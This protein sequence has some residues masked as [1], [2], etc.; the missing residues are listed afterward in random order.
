MIIISDN[1]Y[2]DV[3]CKDSVLI[4]KI[5][6]NAIRFKFSDISYITNEND[7]RTDLKAI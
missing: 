1:V 3:Y 4:E 6:G 2:V 7:L 5:W